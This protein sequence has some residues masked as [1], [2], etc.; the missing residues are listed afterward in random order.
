MACVLACNV[1]RALPW[2]ILFSDHPDLSSEAT[3]CCPSVSASLVLLQPTAP[4]P[5][6]P[7][8]PRCLSLGIRAACRS[9][10]PRV[11]GCALLAFGWWCFFFSSSS[12]ALLFFPLF[13]GVVV[14]FGISCW[15]IF[16]IAQER[17]D[18]GIARHE[19]WKHPTTSGLTDLS[20]GFVFGGHRSR[21][22]R[23]VP[24]GEPWSVEGQGGETLVQNVG[25]RWENYNVM[26]FWIFTCFRRRLVL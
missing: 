7:P 5:Q 21:D 16:G 22:E 4:E 25:T 11:R 19:S 6:S 3:D 13:F 24:G 14:W 23:G 2:N 9:G 20:C 12:V 17:F 26:E 10:G 1:H 18:D 15:R 8:P